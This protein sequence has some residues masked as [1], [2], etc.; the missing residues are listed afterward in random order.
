MKIERK[1]FEDSKGYLKLTPL[2]KLEFAIFTGRDYA[3]SGSRWDTAFEEK[4]IAAVEYIEGKHKIENQGLRKALEYYDQV[5]RLNWAI[6]FDDLPKIAK[7]ALDK[8][9]LTQD[10]IT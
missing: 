2:E 1:E 8:S 9:R 4:V 6:D 10:V 5:H 7:A 3:K